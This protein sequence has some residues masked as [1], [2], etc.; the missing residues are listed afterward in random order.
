MTDFSSPR[1][2]I[3]PALPRDIADVAEFTKYIWEGHDYVGRIFPEWLEDPNG[4]LIVAEYAGHAVG[5]GK[6]SL[7]APG[8][9]WLEGLRVDPKFQGLRIGSQL[10]AYTNEWWDK[11]GDGALRL[12]TGVERV[13]VQHLSEN[14]GFKRV[15]KVQWLQA[16]SISES[17]ESFV[18]IQ[19][20]EAEEAMD[21]CNRFRPDGWMNLGWRFAR[22]SAEAIRQCAQENF[23]WWW[24][25]RRG[26]VTGWPDE[27]A[28]T[29]L[30]MVGF[31]ACASEDH[32]QMLRDVRRLAS[33]HGKDVAG[34]MNIINDS[35]LF[36]LERT[37]YESAW[38]EEWIL[39][40]RWHH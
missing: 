33:A 17:N 37:G 16:R 8:A 26:V 29:T 28:S 31:E 24:R 2:V 35:N 7:A 25:G 36:G 1:V 11:H 34:W 23:A 9:W 32:V 14:R 15:G 40:E 5:T 18:P 19:P 6:L 3:R 21:L 10:D 39:Y 12:L 13:Q 4:L 30:L 22:P 27:E 38:M 20:D